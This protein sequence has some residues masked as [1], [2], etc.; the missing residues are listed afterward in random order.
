M[1]QR[2]PNS[3][4]SSTEPTAVLI[5]AY[6]SAEKLRRCLNSV[7]TLLPDCPV[8]IWDNSGPAY[9]EVRA[10]AHSMPEFHWYLGGRNIGFAAAI[11]K[12]ASHSAPHDFLLLNPDAELASPLVETLVTLREPGIAAVG[13]I[14]EEMGKPQP[15]MPLR[16]ESRP[17]DCAR[18][19]LTFL[20]AIGSAASCDRRL[21]G[22]P[23]S[24]LYKAPPRYVDGYVSG[25][26]LAISRSAWELI[27]PFDE[28]FF[29]YGEEADWQRRAIA[30]GWRV[31][32]QNEFGYRH[33]AGGT[34]SGDVNASQRSQD[35]LRSNLA[36]SLEYRYG[37]APANFYLVFTAICE[38]V[39]AA[40]GRSAARPMKIAADFVIPVDAT[41]D[42]VASERVQ[43]AK[44]LQTAGYEVAIVAM[45]RLGGLP[46]VVPT[47]IRLLRWPWWWPLSTSARSTTVLTHGRKAL[48]ETGFLLISKFCRRAKVAVGDNLLA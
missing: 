41:D 38:L 32:L 4:L 12:L 44:L 5:V 37:V 25:A 39:R 33:T 28:E 31:A 26:C 23:F 30:A 18:R 8:Y 3:P 36:L 19:R 43:M 45:G 11:N 13:P 29:L 34:V 40:T 47:S 22:T 7:R 14:G 16:H 6:R 46:A 42:T 21:R 35:L 20:S 10:L 9:E 15:G 27:G 2:D 24:L 48:R 1:S 17:W